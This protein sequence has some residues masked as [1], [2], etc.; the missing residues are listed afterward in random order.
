M[1]NTNRNQSHL[2]DT[3]LETLNLKNSAALARVLE[4]PPAV[5]SKIRHGRLEVGATILISMHEESGLSIKEL[6]A[7]M[8]VKKEIPVPGAMDIREELKEQS[9]NISVARDSQIIMAEALAEIERLDA[10][11]DQHRLDSH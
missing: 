7:L 3:L 1:P 8:G 9:R 2:I 10:L 11:V 4:V 5:I 6:R